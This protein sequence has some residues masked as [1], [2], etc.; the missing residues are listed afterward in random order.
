[1]PAPSSSSAPVRGATNRRSRGP[2]AASAS[3]CRRRRNHADRPGGRL[4]RERASSDHHAEA[5][6]IEVVLMPATLAGKE[7]TVTPTRT[8]QWLGDIQR[9]IKRAERGDIETIA[10][11]RR[12]RA[13]EVS[14]FKPV[15]PGP[16]ACSH[17]PPHRVCAAWRRPSG[18]SRTLVFLLDSVPF[19]DPFGDGS[20]GREGADQT[21]SASRRSTGRA[22]AC[23][24]QLR[25][26]RRHQHH[27]ERPVRDP[28][29]Q[30]AVR[31]PW[32]VPS[33]HFFRQ[34][35]V[36]EAGSAVEGSRSRPTA[37]RSC[38]DG[39]WSVDDKAAID[40]T[41]VNVKVDLRPDRRDEPGSSGTGIFGRTGT[42]P[43]TAP[44][45][46]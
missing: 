31:G 22:R 7:V 20:T 42:T 38:P 6:D 2:R 14:T 21:P 28:R 13:A 30:A 26:G 44:S 23:D 12:R 8:E 3:S 5:R 41:N 10:R 46:R 24:R 40:F 1:M 16:E 32:A 18:V 19:N 34:R 33:S 27:D 45:R 35:H 9:S 39:T 36:G 15:P 11:T 17:I 43:S 4:R 25:D 37:P 29:T